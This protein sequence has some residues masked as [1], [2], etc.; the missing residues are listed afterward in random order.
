M[1]IGFQ[2]TG[3]AWSLLLQT[4]DKAHGTAAPLEAQGTGLYQRHLT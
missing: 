3:W 1:K 4:E 2:Q